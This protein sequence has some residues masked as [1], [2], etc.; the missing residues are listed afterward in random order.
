MTEHHEEK[1][2]FASVVESFRG[3][4]ILAAR[5]WTRNE[6]D[7][8]DLAQEALQR[9]WQ[10]WQEKD[11][12]RLEGWL[13][14]ILKNVCLDWS[15]KRRRQPELISEPDEIAAAPADGGI[16][17]DGQLDSLHWLAPYLQ[18]V[19]GA[20]GDLLEAGIETGWADEAIAR[21]LAT[22]AQ[23]VRVK[24]GRLR[25]RLMELFNWGEWFG[26]WKEHFGM[27]Y[28]EVRADSTTSLPPLTGNA[29]K[30]FDFWNRKA[31]GIRDGMTYWVHEDLRDRRR[32]LAPMV[33]T[34]LTCYHFA[35]LAFENAA[36][37]ALALAA[38]HRYRFDPAQAAYHQKKAAE[39]YYNGLMEIR[40]V[41]T[42]AGIDAPAW[43]G[44]LE[45]K[46]RQAF[47]VLKSMGATAG[48]RLF[49]RGL[50]YPTSTEPD[51]QDGTALIRLF[52]MVLHVDL[53]SVPLGDWR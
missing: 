34:C 41:L 31:F 40:Q 27:S 37:D 25:D 43:V 53:A 52:A 32:A 50:A 12:E 16:D 1:E 51:L 7:A 24:K 38:D 3:R 46:Y 33:R 6:E 11:V 18:G 49:E 21:R 36:R 10:Y 28:A 39:Q 22:S 14:K 42:P 30:R 44:L 26:A 5:R 48:H 9:A 47:Q 45:E 13:I 8:E 17:L 19:G 35:G 20:L 4:L 29:M 15:T 23:V 2:R